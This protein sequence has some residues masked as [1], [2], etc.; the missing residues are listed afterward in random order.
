MP[1]NTCC[2]PQVSVWEMPQG[3]LTSEGLKYLG[4]MRTTTSPAFSPS[5]MIPTSVTPGGPSQRMG[6]PARANASSANFLQAGTRN[7]T[8][9]TQTPCHGASELSRS[10]QY[11]RQVL[12]PRCTGHFLL[13]VGCLKR[14]TTINVTPHCVNVNMDAS[15]RM[16]AVNMDEQKSLQKCCR[17]LLHDTGLTKLCMSSERVLLSSRVC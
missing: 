15:R 10:L 17:T 1:A 11:Q 13:C 14:G 4:L 3:V 9:C 8:A 7:V 6:M 12:P 5:E 16:H 2:R